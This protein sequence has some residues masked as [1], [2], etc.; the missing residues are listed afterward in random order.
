M[1]PGKN[2]HQNMQQILAFKRDSDKIETKQGKNES[3]KTVQIKQKIGKT[4]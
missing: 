2:Y 1:V 3:P 4:S